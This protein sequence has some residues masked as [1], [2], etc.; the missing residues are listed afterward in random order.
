[1]LNKSNENQKNKKQELSK[2]CLLCKIN[3][4]SD[5][6]EIKFGGD[7]YNFNSTERYIS[8]LCFEDIHTSSSSYQNIT[9]SSNN[10]VQK[11][12]G[13]KQQLITHPP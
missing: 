11:S 10:L 1:V 6:E 3:M 2:H 5:K 7:C 8:Q 12:V 9:C 13:F 4:D